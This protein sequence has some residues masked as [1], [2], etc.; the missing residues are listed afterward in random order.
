MLA[1]SFPSKN[2]LYFSLSTSAPTSSRARTA[3][4][5]TLYSPVLTQR[6]TSWSSIW[7]SGVPPM[8]WNLRTVLTAALTDLR[9]T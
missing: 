9:R 5:A 6:S 7:A 4:I 2:V 1:S 3:C 8:E